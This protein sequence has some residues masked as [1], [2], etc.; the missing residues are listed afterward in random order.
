MGRKFVFYCSLFFILLISV[1]PLISFNTLSVGSPVV[2]LKFDTGEEIQTADVAP[3]DSGLVSFPG[4][5]SAD[6]A[7]G[8]TVQDVVVTLEVSTDLGWPA[9]IEPEIVTLTPGTEEAAF[10]ATV[11]VPSETLWN[12]TGVLTVSGTAMAYPGALRY[13]IQSI[14]G[15]IKINQYYQF[16]VGCNDP[17]KECCPNSDICY[18]ITLYNGGNG[19]TL[20]SV[21]IT[22]HEYL[23]RETFTVNIGS[24]TLEVQ[25]KSYEIVPII[26]GTPYSEDCLGVYDIEVKITSKTEESNTGSTEPQMYTLTAQIKSAETIP[27]S[28]GPGESNGETETDYHDDD[29]TENEF[30]IDMQFGLIIALVIII[31]IL[32]AIWR[33]S[34]SPEDN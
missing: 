11:S 4:T 24:S 28:S 22:N 19:N 33:M 7:A 5:V 8:G 30:K 14:T 15:T 27:E 23:V 9:T 6:L 25:A 18:N 10:L 21:E 20:F 1:I 26:V 31:L 17:F 12:T 13:N 16:S 29:E 2:E 34:L 3:G 32:F